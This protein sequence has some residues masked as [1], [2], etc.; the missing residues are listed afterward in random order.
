MG[1]TGGIGSGKSTVAR[2]LVA[3]GAV[4]VDTDAIAKSLTLAGGAA[5]PGLR[6]RFGDVA[7]AT[8]GSLNRDHIR[9]LVFHDPSARKDL[10]AVLH[11]LIAQEAAAQAHAAGQRTVVFDVPLLAESGTTWRDR[12]DRILVVDCDEATQVQR[13]MARNAW[14]RETVEAI[15]AQQASREQR[16]SLADGLLL[17][18]GISAATLGEQAVAQLRHWEAE[19]AGPP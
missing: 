15:M 8:D 18:E 7:I 1:L 17:N 16:R 4:L 9:S 14:P 11:P 19:R 12:V 2:A 13:V 5:L 3:A 6:A 10:E